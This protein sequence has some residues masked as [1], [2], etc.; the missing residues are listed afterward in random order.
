MGVLR[1]LA[2]R[3]DIADRV[4]AQI[5]EKT[6]QNIY[7]GATS[8]GAGCK[9]AYLYGRIVFYLS[10]LYD[11]FPRELWDIADELEDKCK[12]NGYIPPEG[13]YF[14]EITRADQNEVLEELRRLSNYGK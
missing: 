2:L 6:T 7:C 12:K 11:D 3:N 10:T 9:N 8:L 4:A 14:K 1:L 13:D 5:Y